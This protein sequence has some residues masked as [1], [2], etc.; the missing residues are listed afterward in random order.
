MG[1]IL[2]L[3]SFILIK[4][5]NE[6]NFLKTFLDFVQQGYPFA[7]YYFIFI[8]DFLSYFLNKLKLD[9]EGLSLPGYFV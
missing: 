3:V 1:I 6:M 7:S 5:N 9:I 4:I 8:H 2:L